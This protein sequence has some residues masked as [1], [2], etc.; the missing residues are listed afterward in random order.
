MVVL[1][2]LSSHRFVALRNL[3]AL[4]VLL[5]RQCKSMRIQGTILLSPEGIYFRVSGEKANLAQWF[6][7]LCT[8]P[9]LKNLAPVFAQSASPAFSRIRVYIKRELIPLSVQG[10]QSAH[11]PVTQVQ[12]DE[13]KQWL[14]ENRHFILLDVRDQAEIDRGTFGRAVCPPMK[15]FHEF[16]DALK[17]LAGEITSQPVVMVC[18][19]GMR[20]EK[21]ASFARRSGFALVSFLAGG[22]ANYH[23]QVGTVHYQG[24]CALFDPLLVHQS[25][26]D[27]DKDTDCERCHSPL[28][29]AHRRD[30]RYVPAITCPFCF[31]PRVDEMAATIAK[32]HLDVQRAISPLPGSIPYDNYRPIDVTG[33]YDGFPAIEFLCSLLA[34]IPRSEWLH[35][36]FQGRILNSLRSP[37]H[38]E[39]RV[40]SGE[41]YFHLIPSTT[42]PD[43][44]GDIRILY[45]DETILVIDK[46]APLPLHPS[47][48]FNRNTLQAIVHTVYQPQKPQPAH[49]L[50]ANTT[51]VVVFTRAP[52]FARKVQ[53]QFELGAVK[54]VY[55]VKAMGHPTRTSFSCD[56]P[57]AKT[58]GVAGRRDVDRMGG[59]PAATAFRVWKRLPDG[60]TLLLA[61]PSTGRT[62]QIRIHLWELG[63]PICGDPLYLQ[64]KKTGTTQT[65]RIEDEPLCLHAWKLSF[66]HPS[67]N[68]WMTF[69]TTKPAWVV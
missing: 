29:K 42:E 17:K 55:L 33:S 21:A 8:I 24:E 44:N 25:N 13:L 26:V 35:A 69:T 22:I 59:Q 57:I 31:E 14:D 58:P 48:R 63:F 41:R 39:H 37:V 1:S 54:K 67:R 15:R 5:I 30:P 23:E 11:P 50:D 3:K 20:S 60:S 27:T 36:F 61:R 62:H 7:M 4:R 46:P 68:R 45:E 64:G 53:S 40:R 56:A 6:S 43:V 52:H 47:G 34:H 12:P 9:G 38:A 16:P 66:I 28:T 32:R 2:H 65:R 18:T 51:G 10:I 19:D 49:R